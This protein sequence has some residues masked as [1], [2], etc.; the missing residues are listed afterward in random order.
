VELPRT[1]TM[2][3]KQRRPWV[4]LLAQLHAIYPGLAW[5][6]EKLLV[7]G[8]FAMAVWVM[9]FSGC[10]HTR[11]DPLPPGESPA[12]GVRRNPVRCRVLHVAS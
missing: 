6:V 10:V 12:A 4:R 11:G 9:F 7:L 3:G 2:D 5:V 1:L 8:C